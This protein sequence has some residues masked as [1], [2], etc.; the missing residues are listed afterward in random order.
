MG[1]SK[2]GDAP[3]TMEDAAHVEVGSRCEVSPGARR[4]IVR[5]CGEVEGMSG[6]WVGVR[7]DE[8][9]GKNDGTVKGVRVFEAEPGYGVFCRPKNVVCGDYPDELD[10]SDAEL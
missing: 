1:N 4:G 10:D 9:L 8:P 3:A 7:L 5:F 6:V 2:S